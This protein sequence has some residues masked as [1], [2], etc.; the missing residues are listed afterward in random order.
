VSGVIPARVTTDGRD[1]YPRAIRTE[2]DKEVKHRTDR[3]LNNRIEQDHRGIKRRYAPMG[4]FKSH[5]SATRFRR[6]FDKLR[7]HLHPAHAVTG[8][9]QATSSAIFSLPM[10]PSRSGSW[11]RRDLET[12]RL[13]QIDSMARSLTE[14]LLT[15]AR[16]FDSGVPPIPSDRETSR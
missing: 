15:T 4:G 8:T 12:E 16:S 9:F 1:S 7:N 3:Y 11:K 13:N 10:A 6:R 2:L 5:E 14:P